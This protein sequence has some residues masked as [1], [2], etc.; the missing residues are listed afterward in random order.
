G[1]ERLERRM[2]RVL[3]TLA[4]AALAVS[5]AGCAAGQTPGNGGTSEPGASGGDE[6]YRIGV[7][8]GLTG[9]YAAVSEPQQRALEIIEESVNGAGGINGR[10][11]EFIYLDTESDETKAVNQLRRMAL[12]EN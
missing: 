11:I 9:A 8:L 3:R 1:E 4:A 10:D 5:L 12:Q 6:K 7:L 2:K